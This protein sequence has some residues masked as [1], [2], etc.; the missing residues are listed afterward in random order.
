MLSLSEG[1]TKL[2]GE[3]V[4]LLN[5]RSGGRYYTED[6]EKPQGKSFIN[7]DKTWKHSFSNLLFC[8][9][10]KKNARLKKCVESILAQFDV[11]DV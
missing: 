11:R 7:F 1:G 3:V 5:V 10:P 2:T 9:E 4:K 8:V 6:D